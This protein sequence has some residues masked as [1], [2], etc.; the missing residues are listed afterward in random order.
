MEKIEL[1]KKFIEKRLTRQNVVDFKNILLKYYEYPSKQLFV[2][3][4]LV[5]IFM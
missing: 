4:V 2:E 3:N 5:M 1:E